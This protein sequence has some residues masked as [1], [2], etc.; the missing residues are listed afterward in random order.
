[1]LMYA[2]PASAYSRFAASD[3][4]LSSCWTTSAL[5]S[6]LS[7]C[8]MSGATAP[9]ICC[10]D[11]LLR[12]TASSVS[13]K[14]FPSKGA[15]FCSS[16]RQAPIV[17][18][19]K[20][21]TKAAGVATSSRGS[22]SV[23]ESFQL[24]WLG[25][26]CSAAEGSVQ[27][28]GGRS[29]TGSLRTWPSLEACESSESLL[30]SSAEPSEPSVR[31]FLSCWPWASASERLAL[32]EPKFAKLPASSNFTLPTAAFLAFSRAAS[33]WSNS[34][35]AAWR[36]AAFSA[37]RC[38]S[39]R[40]ASRNSA[41]R[42][43]RSSASRCRSASRPA[44]SCAMR[45]CAS[46]REASSRCAASSARRRSSSTRFLSLAAASSSFLS[47]LAASSA[48][49][50]SLAAA[51]AST[52]AFTTANCSSPPTRATSSESSS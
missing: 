46:S 12:K 5:A 9:S 11:C 32:K 49:F 36:M 31:A 21:S 16:R 43:S 18:R 41:S 35:C 13:C 48:F 7:S 22:R 20:C 25:S 42:F 23:G 26:S 33:R 6:F 28:D 34:R 40:C 50:F 37:S 19:A 44:A 14:S 2:M 39:C 51:A 17:K 1:M 45:R 27:S 3:T 24:T 29:L 47:F 52:A 30:E 15:G 4:I 8:L 10:S 38:R